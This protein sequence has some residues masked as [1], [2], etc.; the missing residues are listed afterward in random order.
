MI[1]EST[2]SKQRFASYKPAREV[3]LGSNDE[4]VALKIRV[5]TLP[6]GGRFSQSHHTSH[7]KR[8]AFGAQND[9]RS[10]AVGPFFLEL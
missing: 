3:P 5:C 9:T 7:A 8:G 2:P 10:N 1:P 6:G 4:N